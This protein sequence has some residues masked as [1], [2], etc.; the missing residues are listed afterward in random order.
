MILEL[1]TR[2]C[3]AL[4]GVGLD[5]LHSRCV[6]KTMRWAA[7]RNKSKQIISISGR[8]GRLQMVSESVTRLYANK[9]L[10]PKEVDCEI[11]HQLERGTKHSL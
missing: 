9:E 2:Q 4:V 6:L 11:P 1:V 10:G 8:F 3:K 7:I 5:P